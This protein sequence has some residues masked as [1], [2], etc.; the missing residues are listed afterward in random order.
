MAGV[1]DARM[2]APSPGLCPCGSGLRPARC[3]ALQAGAIPPPE[4]I[5]HLVPLVERA[6]QA[7]QQGAK[8]VAE[9][10]CLDVLEL[11]PD[12]PGAL[13][14]L[15]SIGKEQGRAIAAQALIRRLVHFEPNNFEATNELALLLLG[16][17]A[18]GEAERSG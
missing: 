4:A 10:L 16:K 7:Y 5:R 8:D 6:I 15:Y 3:C 2:R 9:R 14:V 11:A 13:S 12:R 18:L 1:H 17:G